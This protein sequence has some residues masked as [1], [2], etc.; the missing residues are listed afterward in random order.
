MTSF[1]EL[2]ATSVF[3]ATSA[4]FGVDED[5]TLD[6]GISAGKISLEE[7]AS[8]EGSA[9][10]DGSAPV[11]GSASPDGV[12]VDEISEVTWAGTG[13]GTG[14]G[15][16]DNNSVEV[17]VGVVIWLCCVSS[18]DRALVKIHMATGTTSAIAAT[19]Q[20]RLWV[21]SVRSGRSKGSRSSVNSSVSVES[22]FTGSSTA[23]A[24]SCSGTSCA[25]CTSGTS[26]SSG[27]SGISGT[28]GDSA[29][30]SVSGARGVSDSFSSDVVSRARDGSSTSRSSMP[31]S[32][33]RPALLALVSQAPVRAS[34]TG[35]VSTQFRS[36]LRAA[37][38][39]SSA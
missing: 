10:V 20:P 31:R 32:C 28:S 37:S 18:G 1:G 30:S 24:A 36:S 6:D 15:S 7:V 21:G 8:A 17:G 12:S 26:E 11:E 16:E 38:G 19:H 39:N 2:F 3:C 13:A 29:V 14:T 4:G 33:N 22:S 35:V 25:V 5:A 9:P 23:R 27:I 34:L